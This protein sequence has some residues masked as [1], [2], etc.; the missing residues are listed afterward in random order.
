MSI[1]HEALKRREQADG[2]ISLFPDAAMDRPF[3]APQN[4]DVSRGAANPARDRDAGE[5][6]AQLVPAVIG[7]GGVLLAALLTYLLTKPGEIMVVVPPASTSTASS[8]PAAPVPSTPAAGTIL[9]PDDAYT[10]APVDGLPANPLA[11]SAIPVRA[12]EEPPEYPGIPVYS[13]RRNLPAQAVPAPPPAS[14]PAAAPTPTITAAP[15]ST[16]SAPPGPATPPVVTPVATSVTAGAA[17]TVMS[18]PAP[19]P[20]DL[21]PEAITIEMSAARLQSFTGPVTVNGQVPRPDVRLRVGS[22]IRTDGAGEASMEFSRAQIDLVGASAAQIRRLERRAGPTGEPQEDV[23]LHVTEGTART[24]V[25]PGSGSV[26]VSTDAVTASSSNGAFSV[27]KAKDGS[28]T[29]QNE[30][31]VVRLVPSDRP[32]ESYTLRGA[33]RVTYRDGAFIRE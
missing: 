17:P 26:L 8:A 10:F 16:P 6:A 24:V 32:N 30:G 15:A 1:I 4:G 33:E 28:V 31:G 2:G 9:K 11:S 12:V 27:S 29:I 25:R 7:G 3:G 20:S 14:A 21:P 22:E 13:G 5:T 19:P 23:T 18:T